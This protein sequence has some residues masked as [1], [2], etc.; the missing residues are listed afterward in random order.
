MS[1]DPSPEDGQ[2]EDTGK[3]SNYIV[4]NQEESQTEENPVMNFFKTLVSLN[5]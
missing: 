2:T 3:E 4:E 1:L 5:I